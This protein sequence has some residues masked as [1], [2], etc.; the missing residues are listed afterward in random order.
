LAAAFVAIAGSGAIALDQ[1]RENNATVA[2][3]NRAAAILAEPDSRTVRGVVTGGGN[4]TVVVSKQKDAAVVLVR[5][6]KPLQGRKT[7]QLWLVD[8]AKHARSIGLTNG[9]SLQPTVVTGGVSDQVAFS[10]TVEPDGGSAQ[11]TAPADGVPQ[12]VVNL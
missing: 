2:I 8:S 3:S 1:H 7:Y 6:L 4:V 9:R 12:P 10:V 5:G 11:P